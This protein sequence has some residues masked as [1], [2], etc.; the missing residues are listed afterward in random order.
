LIFFYA[1]RIF[2][3]PLSF[4]CCRCRGPS[5][6]FFLTS[7]FIRVW[8]SLIARR[9]FA[10][11]FVALISPA[12]FLAN[13]ASVLFSTGFFFFLFDGLVSLPSSPEKGTPS[14]SPSSFQAPPSEIAERFP[15]FQ[16]PP[17]SMGRVAEQKQGTLFP[18]VLVVFFPGTLL[19]PRDFFFFF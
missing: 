11:P 4:S 12:T 18:L 17:F 14:L 5:T 6:T 10:T 16:G 2:F 7:D 13:P 3:S 9:P 15:F 19:I 8:S 1:F